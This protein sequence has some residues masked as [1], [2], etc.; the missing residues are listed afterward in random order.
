MTTQADLNRFPPAGYKYAIRRRATHIGRENTR[1]QMVER[2]TWGLLLVGVVIVVIV[3][4]VTLG[5]YLGRG[6]GESP[7]LT[8]PGNMTNQIWNNEGRRTKRRD[9]WEINQREYRRIGTAM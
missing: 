4:A 5:I 6:N 2:R 8:G 9:P 3:T 1:E 7:Q